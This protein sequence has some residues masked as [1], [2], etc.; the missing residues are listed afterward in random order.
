MFVFVFVYLYLCICIRVFVFV[1]FYLCERESF[2]KWPDPCLRGAEEAPEGKSG[3][4][5]GS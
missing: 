4:S 3:I 2:G 1:Y 5:G